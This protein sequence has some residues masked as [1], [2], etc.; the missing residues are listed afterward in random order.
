LVAVIATYRL[1]SARSELLSL[2]IGAALV[3]HIIE[4]E[5]N[6]E[7]SAASLLAWTLA[8]ALIGFARHDSPPAGVSVTQHSLQQWVSVALGVVLAVVAS[9]ALLQPPRA[10]AVYAQALA[11]ERSNQR[12]V[13]QATLT[14]A[15]SIW[16]HEPTYWNELARSHLAVARASQG[17]SAAQ[18]YEQAVAAANRALDLNPSSAQLWAN[19]GQIAGEGA[20][21]SN[22]ADLRRRA[23]EAVDEGTR[24]APGY[25]LTWRAA[26]VTA[27]NL[28]DYAAA[29]RNLTHATTLFDGDAATWSALGDAA[30]I[31]GDNATARAAYDRALGLAPG[32]AHAR[33][34][35]ASLP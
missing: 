14:T 3:G 23:L 25:W 26:G 1:T 16:P 17:A 4:Q 8:G 7:V 18:A 31:A 21:R 15:V 28:A 12:T 20:A 34:A 29:V 22:N 24:R 30:H 27:F 2:G 6:V 32:D 9:V 33:A 13:A 19:L 35:L 5:F 10:D 11:A